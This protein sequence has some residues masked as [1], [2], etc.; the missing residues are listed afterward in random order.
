MQDV[1]WVYLARGKDKWRTLA[2]KVMRF[3]V[4]QNKEISWI[5]E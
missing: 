1:S 2:N 4:L 5:S 3:R